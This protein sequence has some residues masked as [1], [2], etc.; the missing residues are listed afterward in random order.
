LTLEACD[1]IIVGKTA[2]I[3]KNMLESALDKLAQQ[4]LSMDEASLT[5]LW[6]KYKTRMENFEPSKEWEKAVIV[7]FIISAVRTKNEI[8][9]QQVMQMQNTRPTLAPT[10]PRKKGKPNLRLV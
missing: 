7:F 8:F 3:G 9:N 2:R 10:P 4:I 5:S 6:K 1:I